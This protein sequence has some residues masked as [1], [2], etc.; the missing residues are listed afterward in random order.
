MIFEQQRLICKIVICM[1]LY[2]QYTYFMHYLIMT[3][4]IEREIIDK[5]DM[6]E[7]FESTDA[8]HN[9]LKNHGIYWVLVASFNQVTIGFQIYG[10]VSHYQFCLNKWKMDNL[11]GNE[12]TNA[13]LIIDQRHDLMNICEVYN[14][15]TRLILR[16]Y[17][18]L[19][20]YEFFVKACYLIVEYLVFGHQNFA[21]IMSVDLPATIFMAVFFC[22]LVRGKCYYPLSNRM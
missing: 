2:I 22:C 12:Y 17:F 18:I 1:T 14:D 5:D 13:R 20:L 4:L 11:D 16:M 3:K 7:K 6:T 8:V 10:S 15:K 21:Q 9:V 19:H